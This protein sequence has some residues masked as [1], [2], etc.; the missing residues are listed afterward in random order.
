MQD[1]VESGRVGHLHDS[2]RKGSKEDVVY[3]TSQGSQ[4]VKVFEKWVAKGDRRQFSRTGLD[5]VMLI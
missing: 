4:L 2:C 3:G 1:V 5:C